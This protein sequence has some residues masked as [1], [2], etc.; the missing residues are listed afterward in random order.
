MKRVL[1]LILALFA[2]T[3]SATDLFGPRNRSSG[4][5]ECAQVNVSGTMTSALCLTGTATV[6]PVGGFAADSAGYATGSVPGLMSTTT[7]TLAGVKTFSSSPVIT[8]ITSGSGTFT[9]NTS[10]TV[11]VPNVTDTVTTNA[12]TQTLTNKQIS[13]L[14]PDGTHTLTMP[15]LTDTLVSRTNVETLS[16]KTISDG[17]N[18]ISLSA[19]TIPLGLNAG[20]SFTGSAA[21]GNAPGVTLTNSASGGNSLILRP[22]STNTEASVEFNDTNELILGSTTITSLTLNAN[23][24]GTIKFN[25]YANGTLSVTGGTGQITSSSDSR[26]KTAVAKPLYGLAEVMKLTPRFYKWNEE[27]KKK[28]DA[29]DLHLGFF[30][31]E[32]GAVIPEALGQPMTPGGYYGLYDRPITAAMVEAI[33]ELKAKNDAL[34]KRLEDAG[35]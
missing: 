5:K 18:T 3:A 10:G 13:S 6:D 28:G 34:E 7:Q 33:K 27:L 29:A 23:N 24:N 31:Q 20:T 16:N 22:G 25:Q 30:A 11:T 32:A 17:S 1:A 2:A 8:S 14:T 9:P 21:S 35:L 19:N 4:G 15:N 12:A 26:L